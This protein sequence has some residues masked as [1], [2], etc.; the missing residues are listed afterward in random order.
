MAHNFLQY[1]FAT[2]HF[3]DKVGLLQFRQNLV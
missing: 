1:L 3:A 2:L